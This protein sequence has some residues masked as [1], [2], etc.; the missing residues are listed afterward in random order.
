MLKLA[1]C[2]LLKLL[3]KEGLST[4]IATIFLLGGGKTNKTG[5]KE[6]I[7]ALRHK[8]LVLYTIGALAM[9]FF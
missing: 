7:S 6:Y 3:E 2:S 1:D 8:D 9:L 4:C 5:N